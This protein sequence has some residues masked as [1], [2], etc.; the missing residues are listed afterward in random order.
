MPLRNRRPAKAPPAATPRPSQLFS[1]SEQPSHKQAWV[2]LRQAVAHCS[3]CPFTKVEESFNTQAAHD[4]L[5][6]PDVDEW[7]HHYPGPCSGRLGAVSIP[8]RR[9]Y[10]LRPQLER[11]PARARPSCGTS[12]AR[13]R[14]TKRPEARYRQAAASSSRSG[15]RPRSR[16]SRGPRAE[17]RIPRGASSACSPGS[18]STARSTRRASARTR[19]AASRIVGVRRGLGRSQR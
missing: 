19:R 6:V 3:A 13:A 11:A 7:D 1:S 15:P 14:T 10:V 9:S 16:D 4:A 17:P 2:A 8:R 5:F 18:S 12:W